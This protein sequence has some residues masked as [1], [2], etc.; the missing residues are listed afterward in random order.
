MVVGDQGVGQ[1]LLG[2]PAFGV[3]ALAHRFRALVGHEVVIDEVQAQQ[4]RLRVEHRAGQVGLQ[5]QRVTGL[6]ELAQPGS[7]GAQL[8]QPHQ[9]GQRPELVT[10]QVL[11]GLH[12]PDTQGERHAGGGQQGHIVAPPRPR[13]R[14]ARAGQRGEHRRRADPVVERVQQHRPGVAAV[15][16]G[17]TQPRRP[18]EGPTQPVAGLDDGRLGRNGLGQ[19]AIG[20]TGTGEV[21]VGGV[22]GVGVGELVLHRLGHPPTGADQPTDHGIGHLQSSRDLLAA[23]AL[24]RPPPHLLP[25][26]AG[27]LHRPALHLD[28]PGRALLAGGLAQR[29]QVVRV[30]LEGLR[31]GL[32]RLPGLGQRHHRQPAHPDIGD[33]EPEQHPSP[34]Q[35]HRLTLMGHQPQRLGI[36]HPLQRQFRRR[37]HGQNLSHTPANLSC[38]WEQFDHKKADQGAGRQPIPEV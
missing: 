35:H 19:L 2:V 31:D 24:L 32:D 34:R 13:G 28:Q 3:V 23:H 7:Q 26:R 36:G 6:G 38:F 33:R 5:R 25:L 8:G 16:P 10:E 22:G 1:A 18:R 17:R 21:G 12:R 37:G 4:R 27:Q 14:R 15:H 29:G 30:H 11:G 20:D 9:P